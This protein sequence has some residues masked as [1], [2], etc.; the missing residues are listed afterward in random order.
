MGEDKNQ[1]LQEGARAEA[2]IDSNV[3]EAVPKSDPQG[4]KVPRRTRDNVELALLIGILAI[5][6]GLWR[7][8]VKDLLTTSHTATL[9]DLQAGGGN[10]ES[11]P[12]VKHATTGEWVEASGLWSKFGVLGAAFDGLEIVMSSRESPRGS[13]SCWISP[14]GRPMD[15]ACTETGGASGLPAGR[16]CSWKIVVIEISPTILRGARVLDTGQSDP[17]C[18]KDYDSRPSP[19]VLERPTGHSRRSP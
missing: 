7:G 1:L 12:E 11:T 5:A 14:R 8:A 9:P 2:E 13:L 4:L 10:L 6:F 15:G 19:F 3:I 17:G 16:S 18:L